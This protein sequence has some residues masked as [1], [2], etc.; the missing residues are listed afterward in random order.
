MNS[1]VRGS[2]EAHRAVRRTVLALGVSLCVALPLAAQ[3]QP[4]A[5]YPLGP[6]ATTGAGIAPYFDGWYANPDGSVT[7]SFGFMN[8][9]AS[10]A[11]DIPIGPDNRIK[12]TLTYPAS[13]GMSFDEVLRTLDALQLTAD[14]SVATPADWRYGDEV[15]ISPT[16]S[17]EDARRKFPKGFTSKKPYYRVTPQP[18]L[19]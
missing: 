8:R 1:G 19:D 2:H 4:G 18:N 6:N 17:D 16:V 11:V 12:L 9:N 7:L 15:V 14:Y 13:L 3:P 5:R 10:G